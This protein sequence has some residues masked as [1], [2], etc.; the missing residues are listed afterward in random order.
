MYSESPRQASRPLSVIL[1]SLILYTT[2]SPL[3]IMEST[4]I[5]SRVILALQALENDPSL[6][7]RRAVEIYNCLRTILR[8]RYTG[9]QSR[10]DTQPNS[11]K[12][13]NLEELVIV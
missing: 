13:T 6:T 7:T 10:C 8:D 5:E 4:S 2:F 9:R 1:P 11:R 12:L 3:Y